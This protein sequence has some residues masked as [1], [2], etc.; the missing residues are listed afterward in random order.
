MPKRYALDFKLR[1]SF[2]IVSRNIVTLTLDHGLYPYYY[3]LHVQ[4]NL[5][6]GNLVLT[7][8]KLKSLNV[9]SHEILIVINWLLES[10][11]NI[12]GIG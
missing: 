5:K 6:N 1:S 4:A 11:H 8:K 2:Q 10:R 9:V 7:L 12:I 3:N